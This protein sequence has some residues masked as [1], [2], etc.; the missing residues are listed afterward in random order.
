M[1]TYCRCVIHHSRKMFGD[2]LPGGRVNVIT[3]Q[4]GVVVIG[5]GTRAEIATTHIDRGLSLLPNI[6]RRTISVGN[7]EACE[8]LPRTSSCI[9]TSY[10]RRRLR[11]QHNLLR[12]KQ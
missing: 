6:D 3:I 5:G 8:S 4:A 2:N 11:M 1:F 10:S 9:L 7:R 12:G